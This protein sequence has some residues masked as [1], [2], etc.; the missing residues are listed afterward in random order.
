MP[1]RRL[2]PNPELDR[3]MRELEDVVRKTA[4]RSLLWPK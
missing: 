4:R 1:M 2:K 3:A